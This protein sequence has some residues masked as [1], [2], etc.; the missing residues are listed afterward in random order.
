M[1]NKKEADLFSKGRKII[2]IIINTKKLLV[3]VFSFI[4]ISMESDCSYSI[5]FDIYVLNQFVDVLY[6]F[7]VYSCFAIVGNY[8][9]LLSDRFARE[10]IRS[11]FSLI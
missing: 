2:I 8:C 6:L 10:Q 4:A 5:V 11:L 3:M 1:Y 9:V 7:Y